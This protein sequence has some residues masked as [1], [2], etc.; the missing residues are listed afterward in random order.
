MH[1]TDCPRCNAECTVISYNQDD[2]II[3]CNKCGTFILSIE[4]Q[5]KRDRLAIISD[6]IMRDMQLETIQLQKTFFGRIKLWYKIIWQ[7]WNFPGMEKFIKKKNGL[8]KDE[9]K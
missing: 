3:S 8:K 4:E 1:E 9:P 7:G 2:P 6:K 5:T